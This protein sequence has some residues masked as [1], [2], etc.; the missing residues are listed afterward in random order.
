MKIA[1]IIDGGAGRVLS[2]IPAFQKL[3][4]K[5]KDFLILTPY[6]ETLFHGIPE[7]QDKVFNSEQKGLI[8]KILDECDAILTPEPYRHIPYLKQQKSLAQAFDA[9]I[10]VTDDHS[11]LPKLKMHLSKMEELFGANSIEDIKTQQKKLKTIV[12]QP[13]GRGAKVDR[14][15]IL[16]EETRSLEPGTYIELVKKLAQKY[17]LILYAEP[18]FHMSDDT[19]TFKPVLSDLRQWAAVI[20]YA[21][22]FIGCDSSGQHIARSVDT[23]GT[24]IFG[25]TFPVN[26]SY[27][28]WFNII[29]KKGIKKYSPLRISTSE[30]VLANRINESLME[31]SSKE[32]DE[33]YLNIVKHIEGK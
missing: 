28:D 25:S 22:Y 21:D 26:T 10:N 5:T 11:D 19:Y 24:V 13:Y 9:I 16:D 33:L 4:K 31:F 23:K 17:N 18:T 20:K 6:G 30:S 14:K 7:L 29:E 15:V 32:V 2:S 8:E 12:I 27:P 3:A 1:Y